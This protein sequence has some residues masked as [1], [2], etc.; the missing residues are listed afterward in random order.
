MAKFF[1]GESET[2]NTF[3]GIK[4]F[5]L[6]KILRGKPRGSANEFRFNKI[7]FFLNPH[8]NWH[9]NIFLR[10]GLGPRETRNF[11]YLKNRLKLNLF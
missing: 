3:H 9:E 2:A 11:M 10:K 6:L 5:Y 1:K 7:V 4:D 8:E